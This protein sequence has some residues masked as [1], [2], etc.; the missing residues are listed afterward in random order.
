MIKLCYART[1]TRKWPLTS[2]PNCICACTAWSTPGWTSGSE[3]TREI[4]RS[5]KKG[6]ETKLKR[7]ETRRNEMRREKNT[8]NQLRWLAVQCTVCQLCSSVWTPEYTVYALCKHSATDA[9][10]RQFLPNHNCSCHWIFLNFS[11]GV[12]LLSSLSSVLWWTSD[13]STEPWN[14]AAGFFN[15]LTLNL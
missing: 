10:M 4:R 2:L 14:S 15:Y 7:V 12:S 6:T 1:E 5:S 13:H 3:K 9:H 11:E 8:A